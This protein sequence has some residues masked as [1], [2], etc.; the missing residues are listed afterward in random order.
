MFAAV[1][2]YDRHIGRYSPKLARKL[3]D[4]AGVKPTDRALDVGC[5]PGALTGELVARL[6]VDHVAAV[7]PSPSFLEACRLRY[8]GITAEVA[9]AESL[10]FDDD[11][12]DVTLAQLVVNFM[13]DPH[14]GVGEMS[15][16]TR[17]GGAVAGAVWDYGGGMT[18]LRSFWDAA[19]AVNPSDGQRDERNMRMATPEELSD[20]WR[21]VGLDQVGV[22]EGVVSASYR[23]FEDLWQPLEMGVGPA[24]AY[25]ASLNQHDRDALKQAMGARLG[26]GETPFE[27]TARAWIVT[28]RVA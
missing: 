14:A 21:A 13:D 18:L 6:G 28:G 19:V 7:D 10:P 15:R 11:E 9:S 16:V 17:P 25:A 1:D 27:L 26:V 23:G 22:S 8:P 4:L 2:A 3:V 12:F 24:G 20:L 5:G